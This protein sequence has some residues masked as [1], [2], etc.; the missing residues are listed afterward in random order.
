[1]PPGERG[2]PPEQELLA[3]RATHVGPSPEDSDDESFGLLIGGRR[4][5]APDRTHRLAHRRPVGGLHRLLYEPRRNHA[6]GMAL[7]RRTTPSW[8][9]SPGQTTNLASGAFQCGDRGLHLIHAPIGGG[10]LSASGQRGRRAPA[11]TLLTDCQS[12]P[13]IQMDFAL[14][15]TKEHRGKSVTLFTATHIRT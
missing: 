15:G 12:L 9:G 2:T 1:M 3:Y 14:M 6:E 11:L 5:S 13:V 10:V 8:T 7:L 4:L